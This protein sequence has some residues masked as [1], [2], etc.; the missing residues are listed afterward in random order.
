MVGATRYFWLQPLLI[1]RCPPYCRLEKGVFGERN[2][3]VLCDQPLTRQYT[4]ALEKQ[5]LCKLSLSIYSG[6]ASLEQSER[7]ETYECKAE[8]QDREDINSK[9]PPDADSFSYPSDSEA[10][11]AMERN[12][13]VIFSAGSLRKEAVSDMATCCKATAL[14]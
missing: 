7:M 12:G 4:D 10:T 9:F 2:N 8:P 6:G 13:T 5:Y 1:P 11:V 14:T 3:Q